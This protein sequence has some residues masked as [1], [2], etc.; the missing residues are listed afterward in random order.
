MGLAAFCT[1]ALPLVVTAGAV[2]VWLTAMLVV[3]DTMVFWDVGYSCP[4]ACT[5]KKN[6]EF[7]ILKIH[8]GREENFQK[9]FIDSVTTIAVISLYNRLYLNVKH[10]V[11]ILVFISPLFF[12]EIYCL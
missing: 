1:V 9:S 4:N 7:K 11:R 8:Y 12:S 3:V 5:L 10:Y 2:T 6:H